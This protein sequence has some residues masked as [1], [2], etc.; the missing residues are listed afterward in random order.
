M[1]PLP[2]SPARSYTLFGLVEVRKSP[3][4]G[5]GLFA[6]AS[7]P[8]RRKFGEY[9]GERVPL[10]EGRRRARRTR[11]LA[12]VEFDD[13]HAIDGSVRGNELRYINHSCSPNTF[14]R[15]FRGHVEFYSLRR[16]SAGEELTC[17]YG[18]THHN[19]KLRCK[20]GSPNCKRYL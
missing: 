2:S 18:E 13:T 3:I 1:R 10:R 11:R 5:K 16:I 9:A 14:M 20:C 6:K 17:R 4:D 7:I 15:I 19:G 8:A 12:I